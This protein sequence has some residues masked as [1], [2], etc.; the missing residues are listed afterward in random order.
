MKAKRAKQYRK[1]MQQYGLTFGFR[2]PYQ[3]LID[4]EMLQDADRFKMDLVKGLERT[5]S[6]KIKPSSCSKS[7][8]YAYRLM[9]SQ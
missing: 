9:V 2:E 1:L 7:I 6:A 5:L 8:R 3:V 4:A